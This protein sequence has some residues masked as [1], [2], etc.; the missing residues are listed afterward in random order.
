[1]LCRSPQSHHL[2]CLSLGSMAAWLHGCMAASPFVPRVPPT[3]YILYNYQGT[4]GSDKEALMRMQEAAL[5][6][7]EVAHGRQAP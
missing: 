1:M 5:H 6:E 7:E 3:N 4:P 2:A